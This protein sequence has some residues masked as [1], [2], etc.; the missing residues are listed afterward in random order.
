MTKYSTAQ[1]LARGSEEVLCFEGRSIS[2]R[3]RERH[4]NLNIDLQYKQKDMNFDQFSLFHSLS[5]V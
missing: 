4:S 3:T 1:K 5:S 2:H